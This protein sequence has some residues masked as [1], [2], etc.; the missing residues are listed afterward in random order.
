[1]EG[2]CSIIEVEAQRILRIQCASEHRIKK[3]LI[4]MSD[5]IIKAYRFSFKPS[6]IQSQKLNDTLYLCQQL[7]NA[8]LSER[9][10]AYKLNRISINY[11][12]QQNQLPDI[13]T[14]NP[15]YKEIHSQ[16]LQ[17]VLKR[18][19]LAFQ[20]FFSRVKKGIKAGFPRFRSINRYDSFTFPQ[21]GFSLTENKLTLSK[22]GTVKLKLSRAVQGK[23]K[24]C[25]IKKE[26]NKWFVIFTVET[27]AETLPK[28]GEE[29][30]L[31]AGI[32]AFMTLSDGSEIDNFKYYEQSQKKLRIA[33]RRV[34]RR[35]KDSN[36]RRKAVLQ[37][38][39]IHQK[40]RNQRNDFQHK[41]STHLVKTYDLIA[42]EK[43]SILGMS[44]GILS[45]QVH[46]AS[47]SSFFDKLKYKAGSAGKSV[48]EVAPHFT[49]Q[50]CSQCGNRVKKD[51][52]ERIHNCLNC[53]L[54]ISRDLNA[55]I[56]ILRLG[57]AAEMS[58]SCGISHKDI[59][60]QVAESVSLESPT[61]TASV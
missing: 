54:S 16:I 26:T 47:W 38:R 28:T 48:I 57:Q 3:W 35:K 8:A 43:L 21:S 19:D 34:A 12:A 20:G 18:V 24:T 58:S 14:T 2:I 42:I 10:E 37:L 50:D 36:R 13:K 39:K 31:D 55:A 56:N 33:Q 60:Y 4:A 17:N 53:G 61:I 5:K 49:S 23:V 51:L 30:G 7:Y 27:K 40:I 11:Q 44:R 9:R 46:D 52:S 29:I 1:M 41:V 25:T 6:K 22:I 32:S 45:K 59:T 15:E